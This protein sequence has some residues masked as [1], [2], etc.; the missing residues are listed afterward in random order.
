MIGLVD[1]PEAIIISRK[2]P[3]PVRVVIGM[4]ITAPDP[5]PAPRWPWIAPTEPLTWEE[6]VE[7]TCYPYVVAVGEAWDKC[8]AAARLATGHNLT[9]LAYARIAVRHA[10]V[11]RQYLA[12]A[13]LAG[14]APWDGI[15]AIARN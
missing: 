12:L 13:C 8:V 1:L 3:K 6:E 4:P 5:R 15:P 2:E 7:I 9:A 10:D 11:A 14:T